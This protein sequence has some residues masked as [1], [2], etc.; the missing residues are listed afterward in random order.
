MT[1]S[2]LGPPR[3]YAYPQKRLGHKAHESEALFQW[4]TAHI[5][6]IVSADHMAE[7]EE[8][9]RRLIKETIA[10]H[11]CVYGWSGGKDS[12]VLHGLLADLGLAG[13]Q[14]LYPSEME[15]PDVNAW[16]DAHR[17]E[18]VTLIRDSVRTMEW[19]AKNAHLL[20]PTEAALKSRWYSSRWPA[21]H[22]FAR[23]NGADLALLGRRSIDGNQVGKGGLR[24][25]QEGWAFAPIHD[26]HH[27]EVMAYIAYHN[28]P[29]PP[30][31]DYPSSLKNGTEPWP[32]WTGDDPNEDPWAFVGRVDRRVLE[33]AAPYFPGAAALCNGGEPC[34]TS[35]A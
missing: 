5:K 20:F 10:G 32:F 13:M 22:R 18:N 29:V 1:D 28:L 17:P 21:Q 23:D 25:W 7:R 6:E 19:A 3:E 26:W 11:K 8:R 35:S 4:V 2:T 34:A 24:R 9:T 30:I 31:Y 12:I 14:F 33:I 27:E 16:Y 15:W